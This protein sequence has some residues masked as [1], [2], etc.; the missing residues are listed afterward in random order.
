MRLLDSPERAALA[1]RSG[2]TR[3]LML[4][5]PE[6]VR[7]LSQA[8]K[9][10][11]SLDP[12]RLHYSQW[13]PTRPLPE[14]SLVLPN[15]RDAAFDMELIARCMARLGVDN[16]PP[17]RDEATFLARVERLKPLLDPAVRALANQIRILFAQHQALRAK[18]KGRLPLSQIEA[19]R[20]IAEQC[21]ALFY[22]GM[23]WH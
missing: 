10:D 11:R 19:A 6:A 14:W 7:H 22:P 5:L 16:L 12:A 20:E 15:R 4:A 2:V 13:S 1:H 23:V 8:L 3:L 17:V 21:D 18:L 9:Q